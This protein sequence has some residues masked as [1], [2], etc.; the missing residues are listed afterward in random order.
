MGAEG[1]EPSS[2]PYK[3]PALTV[4]LRA[5]DGDLAIAA[6]TSRAGGI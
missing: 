5:G 4:E 2:D 3:R 1:V 6:S